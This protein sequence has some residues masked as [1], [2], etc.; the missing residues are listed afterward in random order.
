MIRFATL[1]IVLF[2]ISACDIRAPMPTPEPPLVINLN[3][4]GQESCEL[5]SG[6]QATLSI[7]AQGSLPANYQTDWTSSIGKFIQEDR[8]VATYQAP[9]S[10]TEQ[11]ATISIMVQDANSVIA[12]DEMTC[13][14]TPEQVPI[15][16]S[17]P[18]ITATLTD[19]PTLPATEIPISTVTETL[20]ELTVEELI[21]RG[22]VR[23]GIHED[24]EPFSY[25]NENGNRVGFEVD[26]AKEFAKRWFKGV[27]TVE[28]HLV[29]GESRLS[30]VEDGI[31]DLSIAAVTRTTDRCSRVNCTFPYFE[32]GA[33][34]LVRAD[35]GIKGVCELDGKLVSATENTTE[36]SIIERKMPDWCE[37]AV[38][39]Q[40]VPYPTR[41]EAIEAVEDGKVAAYTTDGI[42][43]E[44]FANRNDA[45]IVVGDPFSSEPYSVITAKRNNS[46][47]QLIE[48][49]LQEMKRDGTYN[50]LFI[51]WF[52]CDNVPYRIDMNTH[53]DSDLRDYATTNDLLSAS[54]PCAPP[55]EAYLVE[56]GDTLGGIAQ[57]L[58]GA[59]NLYPCIH[60][61]NGDVIGAN[62]NQMQAGITLQIP[63]IS[64]CE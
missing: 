8:N 34:I 39:P 45:L 9:E 46:I 57:S 24:F 18:I 56:R 13:V 26:I 43:L 2:I 54:E 50:T 38:D 48:V 29:A 20:G 21:V 37:F 12:Q 40:A 28:F 63:D 7:R 5:S 60:D 10:D 47:Q 41:N 3:V 52:G 35:S 22:I 59:F 1:L 19:T 4:N 36:P 14:I 11:R 16:E 23:I 51:R 31:V 49:T 53:S 30:A 44:G 64:Q 25:E 6:E 61:L 15:Q 17:E 33:R 42:G 58:L 32:D 27:G 62:P 55:P